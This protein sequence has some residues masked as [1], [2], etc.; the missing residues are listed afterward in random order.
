MSAPAVT[1]DG[2]LIAAPDLTVTAEGRVQLRI[3]VLCKE[4]TQEPRSKRWR[5]TSEI[6]IPCVITH[7]TLAHSLERALQPGQPLH[8]HGKWRSDLG[9]GLEVHVA[10]ITTPLLVPEPAQKAG[11][12][13]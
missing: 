3:A 7:S 10:L 4:H 6:R 12:R 2:H 1:L 5:V 11:T 9:R 13:P 8:I